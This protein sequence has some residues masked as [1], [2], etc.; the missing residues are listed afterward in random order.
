[1]PWVYANQWAC[2][3]LNPWDFV[4]AKNPLQKPNSPPPGVGHCN[5]LS[6]PINMLMTI[7]M[8]RSKYRMQA[9][10]SLVDMIA[11][12]DELGRMV[13]SIW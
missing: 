5:F 10:G 6:H 2:R 7:F 13:V 11:H 1:M 9:T 3:F 4:D 8:I 12:L